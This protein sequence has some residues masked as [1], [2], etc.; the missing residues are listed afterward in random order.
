MSGLEEKPKSSRTLRQYELLVEAVR[1][2]DDTSSNSVMTQPLH[3]LGKE[4]WSVE[5]RSIDQDLADLMDQDYLFFE[6]TGTGIGNFHLKQSGRDAAEEFEALRSNKRKR[7]VAIRHL[8]LEWL[9][10]EYLDGNESPVIDGFLESQHGSFYG[11][12]FT[13]AEM[14]RTSYWLRDEGYINGDGSLGGPIARPS[15][16]AKG[17]KTAE[18]GTLL[19]APAESGAGNVN[20]NYNLHVTNSHGF[21]LA[22]GSPGA[23][24][25]NT[26]TVPQTD[27][28]KKVAEAFRAMMPM[29]GLSAEV[30]RQGIGIR[31]ELEGAL[32]QPEPDNSRVK[33]LISKA[34]EVATL[35]TTSGVV[36]AFIGLAEKFMGSI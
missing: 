30:E 29:F 12:P 32:M 23:V 11:S 25:S 13:E 17:V 34:V 8:M 26:L 18:H 27:E 22:A 1:I 4:R 3:E 31:D 28:A 20:N 21:N 6:R 16:T 36:E 10:D 9:H 5:W 24:Q 19:S 15:L 2:A 14:S 35:G 33:K 7:A